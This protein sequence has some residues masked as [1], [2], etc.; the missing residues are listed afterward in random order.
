MKQ[1]E[2]CF[3]S[4][5]YSRSPYFSQGLS[6][7]CCHVG[8]KRRKLRADCGFLTVAGNWIEEISNLILVLEPVHL[9]YRTTFELGLIGIEYQK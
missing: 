1:A 8:S 2:S 7:E 4:D 3:I 6:P 9:V 5:L